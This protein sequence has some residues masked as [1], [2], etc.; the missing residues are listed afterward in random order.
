MKKKQITILGV[1]NILFSDEGFGV[2]VVEKLDESYE[3][4]ENVSI[5]DG[6]VL[7]LN[8]LGVISEADRLIVIDAVRNKG[9]AGTFERRYGAQG[10]GNS[11][12]M[13]DPDGNTVELRNQI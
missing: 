12:Y 10:F 7:G 11:I 1:G 4:P 9:E 5:I 3:F 6:G 13:T 8:L 2:R